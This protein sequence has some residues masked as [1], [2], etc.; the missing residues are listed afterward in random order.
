[1][2]EGLKELTEGNTKA[3]DKNMSKLLTTLKEE[4]GTSDP[5]N[6]TVEAGVTRVTKLTKPAKV[7]SWMKDMSLETY[8][9]QLTTWLEINEDVPEH[10]KYHN[11]TKELKRNKEIKF[12]KIHC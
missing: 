1:M 12:A 2:L 5:N 4:T 10:V 9:K 7:L 6:P 8:N 11:L 3:I